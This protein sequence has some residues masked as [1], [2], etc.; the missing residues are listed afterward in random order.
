ML[1]IRANTGYTSVS[2]LPEAYLMA[3]ITVQGCRYELQS[4]I[5]F[6]TTARTAWRDLISWKRREGGGAITLWHAELIYFLQ[7]KG[8]VLSQKNPE[9]SVQLS[10]KCGYFKKFDY[11]SLFLYL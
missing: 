7:G 4:E 3:V 2:E 8:I 11:L 10:G 1:E 6:Y 5:D 9:K